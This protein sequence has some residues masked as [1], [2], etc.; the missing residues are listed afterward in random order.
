MI[1]TDNP[2]SQSGYAIQSVL[3]AQRLIKNGFPCTIY[4]GTNYFGQDISYK[5]V[6][7]IGGLNSPYDPTGIGLIEASARKTN[8]DLILL[9]K[10]P[11][12]FSVL[13]MDQLK[14]ISKPIISLAPVDTEPVSNSTAKALSYSSAVIALTK[15]SQKML[16]KK[17]IQSLFAPHGIDTSFWR[18]PTKEEKEDA[19]QRLK[20]DGN[21]NVCLV[22]ANQSSPSRKSF[23][24]SVMAI[25]YLL[26]KKY[27]KYKN[28]RWFFHTDLSEN[29]GGINLHGLFNTLDIPTYNV[30]YTP[31]HILVA[32]EEHVRDVYWTS[33]FKLSVSRGE[34]FSLTDVESQSCGVPVI[35]N[36][37]AAQ[38]ETV[39]SGAK[40]A[41]DNSSN[42][43]LEYIPHLGAFR[44][45]PNHTVVA[46]AID[47]LSEHYKD[48]EKFYNDKENAR[49]KAMAYDI[50]VVFNQ[51]WLPMWEH[52][53][54]LF[55]EGNVESVYN[56]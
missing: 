14:R 53:K 21:L 8:S 44:F 17:G 4:A 51:Y 32:P 38:R 28:S 24:K 45:N 26:E 54:E 3:L 49:H 16:N 10:D 46:K 43:D 2:F 29:R 33:D 36:D 9:F 31:Q 34:G 15:F 52:F 39:W 42:G 56:G 19:K 27:E 30:R 47:E 25:K 13:G 18:P 50:D 12:A 23:D 55:V 35:S 7:V 48:E 37:F 40:I 6:D 41:S 1:V 20:M 22:G 11:H 5:G